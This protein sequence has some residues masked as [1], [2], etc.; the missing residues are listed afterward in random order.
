MEQRIREVI[1]RLKLVR[2]EKDMSL[3]EIVDLCA[4][5]G[6]YVS[7]SSVRRV[8]STDS[9]NMSFRYETTIQPIARVLLNLDDVDSTS[10]AV[11]SASE[12]GAEISALKAVIAVKNQAMEGMNQ[13]IEALNRSIDAKD[14]EIER[15]LSTTKAQLATR[16]GTVAYLKGVVAEQKRTLRFTIAAIIFLL[17]LV[18]VALVIDKINPEIGFFWVH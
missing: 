5:N 2:Q 16:E 4:E 11:Q 9:E 13:T 17:L 3:Q 7:M 1:T 6:N 12:I 15:L 18:I 10:E 14:Q 8:F